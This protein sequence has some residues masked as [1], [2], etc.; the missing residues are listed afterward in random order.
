MPYYY[1]HF[2]NKYKYIASSSETYMKLKFL[3]SNTNIINKLNLE[4]FIP[5]FR[6]DRMRAYNPNSSIDSLNNL[7]S[8][9]KGMCTNDE[10]KNLIPDIDV[11]IEKNY[12]LL[13][14]PINCCKK[15]YNNF[16]L[17]IKMM[18]YNGFYIKKLIHIPI[19]KK[20]RNNQYLHIWRLM[21]NKI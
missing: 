14:N 1:I 19:L 21:D 11:F 16:Y 4:I 9:C 17:P 10:S 2:N 20:I 6:I 13:I 7:L 5:E 18:T 3:E 12:D 8:L 15:I